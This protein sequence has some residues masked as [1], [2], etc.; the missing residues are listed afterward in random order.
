MTTD[1]RDPRRRRGPL[2]TIHR[3]CSK[4]L[5]TIGLRSWF[6]LTSVNTLFFVCIYRNPCHFPLCEEYFLWLSMWMLSAGFG[7]QQ[8]VLLFQ[9]ASCTQHCAF[10]V[11]LMFLPLIRQEPL[12]L[13]RLSPCAFRSFLVRMDANESC[14]Y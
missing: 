13:F 7:C 1:K 14:C 6:S 10:L 11:P 2:K 9:W 3:R 8:T 5:S 4:D 12:H